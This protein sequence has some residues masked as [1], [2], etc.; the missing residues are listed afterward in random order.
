MHVGSLAVRSAWSFRAGRHL[1]DIVL[2]TCPS[3]H[4]A[5]RV[6]AARVHETAKCGRCKTALPPPS[7]PID[8]TEAATFDALLSEAQVPMLVDFWAGW[9]GPCRMVAPEVARVASKLAGRA[10]VVK[11]DT[12]R[13]PALAARYRVQSIPNFVVIQHGRVVR[14][15]PGAMRAEEL[16]RLVDGVMA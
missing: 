2:R 3:C 6:P 5:N 15:Q 11:V 12:E 14:Q 4:A 13:V 1:D 8:I 9:C 7:T 16:A 10:L